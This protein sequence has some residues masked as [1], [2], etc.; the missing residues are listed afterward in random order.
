MTS[1]PS[2]GA[3]PLIA[4]LVATVLLTACSDAPSAP[5][6]LEPVELARPW[7]HVS[8]STANMDRRLLDQAAASAWA[9]PRFRALLVARHGGLVFERYFRGADEHTLFDVRSVT[10]SIISALAGIALRDSVLPDVDAPVARWLAGTYAFD[11]ADS[12][13]TI[14][15]LLT[16][17]SGFQWNEDTGP[18]YN[19]WIAAGDHVQYVLDR[20]HAAPAGTAFT[21]NSAAAHMLGVVLQRASGTPLPTYAY[22]H[23]LRLIGVDTAAWEQLDRG[24][25]NGGS[26]MKLRA[27]DLLRFGQLYLQHGWSGRVS[28]VPDGW[29]QETTQPQFPWRD[30]FGAQRQETYGMLW[31]VSDAQPASFCA[32]GYGGQ[33]VYV[34]PSLD[35]VVVATTDWSDLYGNTTQLDLAE[36]VLGVIVN[37]VIPAAR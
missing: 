5:L 37:G 7:V 2:R 15:D 23:L 36:E 9:N 31:W 13:I 26:G 16:M 19:L 4:A 33:F 11:G 32:W 10:K 17:T 35:L 30:D 12:T 34:V 27:R 21:Y 20:P 29:V 8:P 24:T 28:V 18:D 25:V 3:R 22:D 1:A 14:R 6:P